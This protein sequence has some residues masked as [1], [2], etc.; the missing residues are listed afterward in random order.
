MP[1]TRVG[2]G[3]RRGIYE[4]QN[5]ALLDQSLSVA[6][7]TKPASSHV[8]PALGTVVEAAN[9][10]LSGAYGIVDAL[11]HL[12]LADKLLGAA[13]RPPQRRRA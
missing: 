10:R 4:L 2:G 8:Q 9:F 7:A 1:F 3:Y 12:T 6:G 5:R 13:D 11:C